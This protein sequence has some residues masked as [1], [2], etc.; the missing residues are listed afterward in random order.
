M[1]TMLEVDIVGIQF[2]TEDS[3]A[4]AFRINSSN[5]DDFISIPHIYPV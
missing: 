3:S 2:N 5:K 1:H 4:M